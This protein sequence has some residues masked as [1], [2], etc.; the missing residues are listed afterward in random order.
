M[1]IRRVAFALVLGLTASAGISSIAVAAPSVTWNS[2]TSGSTQ[3]GVVTIKATATPSSGASVSEWCLRIDGAIVR[4]NLA[5]VHTSNTSGELSFSGNFTSSTG[6]WDHAY[7]SLTKGAIRVDTTGWTNGSHTFSLAVRDRG[8]SSTVSS[9][10][11]IV[12]SN[13]GPSFAWDSPASG[14]TQTGVVTIKATATPD[15]SGSSKIAQWCLRKD[16]A[17]VTSDPAVGYGGSVLG[18]N[19]LYWGSGT[20]NTSTGCWVRSTSSNNLT[21]AAIQFDTTAWANGSYLFDF[22][23]TD[24][25]GRSVTSSTLTIV[26]SNGGPSFAWDSPASGSTQTGVVTIKATA[27]PDASGSSKIAQWCL[28]K[29]GAVVTSDPAVGYGGSVLGSNDLYWG[30]GTY[31]TST[32]CWVRSTSSNNLTKA[33]IQFDTTAWA[34]G[35]YLFDF[36]VTDSSGRSVT[37]S[38]LT[39]VTSNGGPS[40]AWDSPAS[41]STQTGV[42]TIKATATPDAS[43][44]SKIAQWCLRKDGAVV[45]SDPAVGYGGSVLGS[46]DL[47]WGSGTYNT[48]TGCWVRSTSSNNLTKAAIQFDIDDL[49]AE[50]LRMKAI[51]S[52]TY[53]FTVTDSSG[54][55]LVSDTMVM[56]ANNGTVTSSRI[57]KGTIPGYAPLI[58]VGVRTSSSVPITISTAPDGVTAGTSYKLRVS[59]DAGATW[60]E[61]DSPTSSYTFSGL[62]GAS[63]RFVQAAAVNAMG[64]GPWGPVELVATRG[65]R[66]NRVSV[67]DS[68]GQPV[69]GGII[70]WRMVTET[71]QS[72][73]SYGLTSDGIIDFPSTPAGMVDI[74]LTDG[75]L[76]DGTL[77]S[78]T[79]RQYLGFPLTE[80][81]LPAHSSALHTVFVHLPESSL[82]VSG[83]EV[84]TNNHLDTSEVV[85]EFTFK[86]PRSNRTGTTDQLGLAYLWGFDIEADT[87]V[88]ANY[89]DSVINQTKT[90][91]LGAVQTN[92]ELDYV[93]WFSFDNSSVT[94]SVGDAVTVVVE[95]NSM[96]FIP[97]IDELRHELNSVRTSGETV[98]LI[99]PPGAKTGACGK[100]GAKAKLSGTVSAAGSVALKVCSNVSGAYKITGTGAAATGSLQVLAKGAPPLPVNSVTATSRAPGSITASWNPPVFNGGASIKKY[101]VKFTKGSQSI[102]KTVT[103]SSITLSGLSNATTYTVTIR[104]YTKNGWSTPYTTKVPVA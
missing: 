14:S 76:A 43:G 41:G 88:S 22:V 62:P 9:T 73:R 75:Q 90:E 66:P 6:C 59:S 35:S 48:S 79:T 32:G 78:G 63:L 51:L 27:T 46:N 55:S 30:S 58:T 15:A 104:A 47:Y 99:A 91:P 82:G 13:G 93:P 1:W 65:A 61:V 95:L 24:S 52:N 11:T 40:F 71:T 7:L 49:A 20:Y 103:G 31:N 100:K 87:T 101:E 19:D 86:V 102:T 54:R 77:V 36:V 18:S 53:N 26:T 42:V 97:Q 33:A 80:I 69:M 4:E 98:R 57:A 17:V 50:S 10:L 64:Q 96:S 38:T 28:R 2:P 94:G 68:L 56:T 70:T 3:Q 5:T 16:G 29:D 89:D 12:T 84:F 34:N 44:S 92:I 37:S 67:S 74:T 72:S 8:S 39:I 23:V 60:N 45:T 81:R 25:S 21:K 85:N 83:V